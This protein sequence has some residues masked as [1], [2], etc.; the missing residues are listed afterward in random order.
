[1]RSSSCSKPLL[2]LLSLQEVKEHKI[3][4]LRSPKLNQTAICFTSL[5]TTLAPSSLAFQPLLLLL[6]RQCERQEG[7]NVEKQWKPSRV[8]NT[9][10]QQP[11]KEASPSLLD[12]LNY[13]APSYPEPGD[14]PCDLRGAFFFAR[15]SPLDDPKKRGCTKE[16][17]ERIPLSRHISRKKQF[18]IAIFRH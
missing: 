1:L 8:I 2:L 3:L 4:P 16:F 5:I 13:Q 9:A 12:R 15:I 11:P 14:C 10:A 7:N 18:E 6:P 17:L